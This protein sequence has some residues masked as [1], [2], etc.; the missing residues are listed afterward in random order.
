VLIPC[1]ILH[2]SSDSFRKRFVSDG[3]TEIG[4]PKNGL[5]LAGPVG[6]DV[7]GVN[8]VDDAFDDPR[9]MCKRYGLGVCKTG[10]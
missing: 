2:Y 8:V 1:D 4:L 3:L 7:G 5:Q 6:V 9:P 10:Q